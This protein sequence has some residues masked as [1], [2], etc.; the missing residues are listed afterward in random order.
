MSKKRRISVSGPASVAS[1]LPDSV[2]IIEGVAFFGLTSRV[3]HNLITIIEAGVYDRNP[4][5]TSIVIPDSVTSIGNCAFYECSGLTSVKIGTSVTSIGDVA[6]RGCT[7]LTLIV[8]PDSV[9][10][11]GNSAFDGCT[12]LTSIVI[13]NSVT[14]I[15]GYAFDGCTG[16]V[17][18]VIPDSV[19]SI[20]NCAFRGC[21]G[22]V[23]IVIPNSVT[24][25]GDQAFRE[26]AGL[27]SI[28]IP[29]SVISAGEDAFRYRT[30]LV[31]TAISI[32]YDSFIENSA[33]DDGGPTIDCSEDSVRKIRN[34][35]SVII[36][37][38]KSSTRTR[39]QIQDWSLVAVIKNLIGAYRELKEEHKDKGPDDYV[40]CFCT[41]IAC[42]NQ[43]L[44]GIGSPDRRFNQFYY[45]H[46][47]QILRIINGNCNIWMN[48]YTQPLLRLRGSVSWVGQTAHS[49]CQHMKDRMDQIALKTKPSPLQVADL[50]LYQTNPYCLSF[51]GIKEILLE[52]KDAHPTCEE[53]SCNLFFG[54][55]DRLTHSHVIAQASPD[56][57]NNR[58]SLYLRGNFRLVCLEDQLVAQHHDRV[59]VKCPKSDDEFVFLVRHIDV[60]LSILKERLGKAIKEQMEKVIV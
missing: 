20:G 19:T 53:C 50:K 56:R 36:G 37:S 11:I 59:D 6:F 26:C 21:T 52:M 45:G 30:E 4:D 10:S 46:W 28:V 15:E 32:D 7:G 9:T 60:I 38:M 42:I 22:L 13:P 27:V 31:S 1:L 49:M 39:G 25:I 33:I 44:H 18:I 12:G 51:E 29:N 3:I 57:L 35:L 41:R 40:T 54:E 8:I 2:N 47:C 5:L 14:S 23:S 58:N 17:S 55:N 24:S 43:Q 48:K 16:L 34:M